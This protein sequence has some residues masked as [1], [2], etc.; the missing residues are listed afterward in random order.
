L[1][2]FLL[3][4]L[5]LIPSYLFANHTKGKAGANF[6]AI[7]GKKKKH[8]QKKSPPPTLGPAVSAISSMC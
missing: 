1:T 7:G 8:T 3:P 4:K 2:Q 6:T 5:I